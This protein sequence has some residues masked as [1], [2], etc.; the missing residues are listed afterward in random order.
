MQGNA[1]AVQAL[2]NTFG[3]YRYFPYVNLLDD[4]R[5]G[6]VTDVE[7][8]EINGDMWSEV[9]R[10]LVFAFIYDG[11]PNWAQTDGV[12]RIMVPGQPE[13]EVRMNEHGSNLG[14]C[15]VVYLENKGGQ[16]KISREITFHRSH[17]YMD[18]AYGWG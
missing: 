2:D 11:A 12:V 5:T 3:D 9:H 10:I 7:W 4:D 1:T 14:M 18:D 13:V 8:L 17:S 6:A 16:I 15:A